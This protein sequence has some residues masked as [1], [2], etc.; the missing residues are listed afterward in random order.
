MADQ[1]AEAD[2]Y[3]GMAGE[4]G[5]WPENFILHSLSWV[6]NNARLHVLIYRGMVPL[7]GGDPAAVFEALFQ[8]NGWPAR[9]RDGIYDYHH[10]HTSAHEVLGF[11]RGQAELM[12]GGPNGRR[13]AVRA[14]D[15]AVLP[16]GTGHCRV[17]ASDDFLVVGGYPPGQDWDI[18]REAATPAELERIAHLPFPPLDPVTG[19]NGPLTQ[20]W[21]PTPGYRM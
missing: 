8:R 3:G 13:V 4:H 19:A 9:W 10:Y 2:A 11:A 15:V 14:G 18:R 6:P 5:R 20:L 17:A 12:L 7:G 21:T 1:H 16:A